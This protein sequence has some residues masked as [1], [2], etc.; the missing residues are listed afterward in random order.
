MSMI[1]NIIT[2]SIGYCT[3]DESGKKSVSQI[4]PEV[5]ECDLCDDT[6]FIR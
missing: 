2:V 1:N 5:F 6:G 4:G 3:S